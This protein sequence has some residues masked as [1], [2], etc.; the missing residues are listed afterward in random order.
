MAAVKGCRSQTHK[1]PVKLVCA[2]VYTGACWAGR[3]VGHFFL[4]FISGKTLEH[5]NSASLV[6]HSRAVWSSVRQCGCLLR[7]CTYERESRAGKSAGAVALEK[8][9]FTPSPLVSPS[10]SPPVLPPSLPPLLDMPSLS[11]FLSPLLLSDALLTKSRL[12]CSELSL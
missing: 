5:S 12:L 11:L 4:C 2:L 8:L 7:K 6:A 3:L 1:S 9:L 10:L